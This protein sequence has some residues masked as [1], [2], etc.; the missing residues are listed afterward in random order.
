MAKWCGRRVAYGVPFPVAE[1]NEA[2]I[3]TVCPSMLYSND[4]QLRA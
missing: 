1:G 3:D 2:G 4:A